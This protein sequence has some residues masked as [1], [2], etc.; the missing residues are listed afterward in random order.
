MQYSRIL[1]CRDS[2]ILCAHL[3]FNMSQKILQFIQTYAYPLY[4][5]LTEKVLRSRLPTVYFLQI[6]ELIHEN[7]DQNSFFVIRLITFSRTFF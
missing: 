1:L 7:C 5:E 2:F 4:L 3:L 6:Q